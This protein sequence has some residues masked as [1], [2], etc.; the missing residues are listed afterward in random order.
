MSRSRGAPLI[1]IAGRIAAPGRVSRSAI[2]FSGRRYLDAV[3]R[4]GGEP[5]TLAPRELTPSAAAALLKRFDALVLMG[6]GDVDP[7]RYGRPRAHH[8][9]G[10]NHEQDDFEVALALTAIERAI[11]TLAICRGVQLVNVA[12]GGT[13]IQ[14]VADVDGTH[15]HAPGQFPAGQDHVLHPIDVVAG[16]K[17]AKAVGGTEVVGASFHHQGIESLGEGL[18][19][20]AHARDGLIEGLE[21][22]EG[23]MIGVQWH[24]EDTAPTDPAQQGLYDAL[25]E[26]A[27]GG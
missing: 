17:L 27:G 18:R 3:L 26:Q 2:S 8:V 9:Y 5:V 22:D 13:L 14:H 23:W 19:P 1:A 11:P 24:P 20:V 7:H 16:S 10:V 6:G 12:L 15:D 21:L 4:A 25:V